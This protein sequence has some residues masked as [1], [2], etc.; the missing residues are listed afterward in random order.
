MATTYEHAPQPIHD[1]VAKLVEQY[2]PRLAEAEVT[3]LIFMVHAPTDDDGKPKGP[4]LKLHGYPCA[5]TVKILGIKERKAGLPDVRLELDADTWDERPAAE[6]RAILDDCLTRIL[7]EGEELDSADRPK[8][9]QRKCD[10]HIEGFDE[11]IRRHEQA[12]LV[13]QQLREAFRDVGP[14]FADW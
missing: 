12:A 10:R 7:V 1:E 4:A 8:L 5:A 9:K 13:A 14:L 11:I 6:Q 2:H 3:Y